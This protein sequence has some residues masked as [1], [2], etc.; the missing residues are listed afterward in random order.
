VRS[1]RPKVTIV[2]DCV[3]VFLRIEYPYQQID[4]INQPVDFD[5]MRDLG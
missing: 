4:E 2:K 5:A 1:E 3:C